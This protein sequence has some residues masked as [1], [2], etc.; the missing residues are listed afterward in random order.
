MGAAITTLFTQ[1]SSQATMPARAIATLVIICVG[2]GLTLMPWENNTV[3][4]LK[5]AALRVAVGLALVVNAAA[6]VATMAGSGS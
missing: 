6:I 5:N 3:H 2:I 4:F 1:L